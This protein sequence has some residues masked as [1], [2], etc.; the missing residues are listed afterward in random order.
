LYNIARYHSLL[1]DKSLEADLHNRSQQL[2]LPP[3]ALI[4]RSSTVIKL[5]GL[6]ESPGGRVVYKQIQKAVHFARGKANPGVPLDHAVIKVNCGPRQF[7]I[8]VR[9]WSPSDRMAVKQCF[10][11]NQYDMP[12]GAHG[13]YLRV[14]YS[15]IVASGKKPLIVDCGANIGASVLWFSARYPQAHIVAVEPAPDNF[16]LLSKNCRN[17]NVDLR[18][19]GVGSSDR[20][21]WL[22]VAGKNEMA[23]RTNEES[24]GIEIQIISM[25]SLMAS[26]PASEFTPFLLKIDV[27]GAEKQLFTA[28]AAVFDQFPVIIIEPHDWMFPGERTSVGFFQFHAAAGREFAMKHENVASIACPKRE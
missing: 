8:E 11:D 9:R 18:Q 20:T 16:A 6:L 21:A 3:G 27:E 26:K 15:E 24:E 5:T 10:V 14:V 4:A 2:S 7:S 19:M 17:L 23:Y 28:P 1:K 13:A 12:D 22:R 25:G